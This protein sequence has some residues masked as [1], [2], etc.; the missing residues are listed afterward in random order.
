M[1][2]EDPVWLRITPI[3]VLLFGGILAYGF[4]QRDALL[5]RFAASRLLDQLT[6]KASLTRAWIKAGCILLAVLAIGIAHARPQLGVEWSERKARGM[7]IVFILDSSKSMLATDLRPTRLDRAKLAI[8]D[9][10]ERLEGDRIGLIA[11][12]G[13]AF[14]QT[15]PTLDYSAF[16]E[17]LDAID[18]SIMTSGGSDLGNAIDEATKAFP[19]QNNV[20]V[21]VL[22]TDGEDLSGNAASAATRAREDGIQVFTIGIGTPEGEYL[23]IRNEQGIE[24]F[25]RDSSGQ[26]VLSKLDENT[27]QTIAQATGG[28]YS[29][30][31]S[32]SLDQLYNS[33]I[34]RLPREERE[35]E[36]QEIGIERFQWA[37]TLALIF[38]VFD[39]LIR[40][41]RSATIHAGMLILATLTLSPTDTIAETGSNP[42]AY[43]NYNAAYRALTQGDYEAAQ[44]GY[45]NVLSNTNDLNLQRDALYNLAHATY[46]QG[47]T[48]Y[49]SGDLQAAL[50]QVEK[51]EAL[52]Q[53]AQEIDTSDTSIQ[54]DIDQVS[55]VREAIEK[56]IEEQQSQ[57]NEEQS[58]ESEENQD[59]SGEGEDSEDS[60]NGE[61]SET[62]EQ[63][64]NSSKDQQNQENDSGEESTEQSNQHQEGSEGGPSEESGDQKNQEA[65]DEEGE[66][67]S[68]NDQEST[69][70]PLDDVPQSQSGEES[71]E[72]GDEE[73]QQAVATEATEGESQQDDQAGTMSS[74]VI[75]G[76]TEAEAAALLDSLRGKET[77]LPFN[78]QA[79]GKRSGDSRDW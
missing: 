39:I 77:L 56:L 75:K 11:F 52:F 6:E 51:A 30:L 49:E 69:E 25:V 7:D 65:T 46:Q 72:S 12:A 70:D 22:L 37:L 79:R 64:E 21:V 48:S 71:G 35:S 42:N 14:L 3:L 26:P 16:R 57:D 45:E 47:H 10:V 59:S 78:N 54:A 20:K 62:S 68:A 55:R 58:G 63:G 40:R 33:V 27:L 13:Q 24:E 18:P 17:S 66:G 34:A 50:I 1:S 4:R 8:I 36:L 41:R 44:A 61:Q 19:S 60:Q 38:L 74:E 31:S 9:L 67:S 76:M 29:Q 2:F 53:S 23:R 28:I 43:S 73:G 32:D 15:P 5:G